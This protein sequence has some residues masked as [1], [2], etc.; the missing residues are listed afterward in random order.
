MIKNFKNYLVEINYI[1][2]N[3]ILLEAAGAAADRKG[4]LRELEIGQH[5]NGGNHME[6]YR[7]E[8]KT[9]SEIHN[10]LS[11]AE[12]GEGYANS[13][14]FSKSQEMAKKAAGHIQK[15]L[16]THGYGKV[17]RTVWTSQ[18]SDHKSET[19]TDDPNTSADLIVSTDK[20]H[21][22]EG[23]DGEKRKEHKI[24]VSVKTG[25]GSVNY[26]NPGIKTMSDMAGTDLSVHTKAH[27]DVVDAHLPKEKGDAHDRYKKLRDSTN[28]EDQ[29]KAAN[30]KHSSV[31]LN[32]NVAHGLR[33]G[34]SSKSH[35]DLHNTIMDSVAPKTHLK[36]IVSR[37]ITDAKT[38]KEKGHHTYDLHNHVD[39]YLKHFMGLHVDPSDSSGTVTVHGYH[40]KTGKKMPVA[41]VSIHAG[42]RP[43]NISPRASIVLPSEDH[44]DINYSQKSEHMEH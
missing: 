36:H 27:K 24:A 26:S 20:H 22:R 38:G 10:K 25:S 16:N 19:G 3:E 35:E 15:H 4:K 39:E 6:S 43:A 34:L 42:G 31:M 30:I 28:V 17:T 14:T 44:K 23:V 21:T 7:A 8:G 12:H 9:P 11:V 1:E 40:K 32:K 18:P 29:I 13:D 37:Q 41:R 33:M 5:L 2:G